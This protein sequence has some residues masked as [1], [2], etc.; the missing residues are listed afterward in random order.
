MNDKW[1]QKTWAKVVGAVFVLG[2]IGSMF[3]DNKTTTSENAT[4][5]E[6]TL[7]SLQMAEIKAKRYL[8]E[9]LKD[10]DSYEVISA[11][12]YFLKEYKGDTTKYKH[13]QSAIKY[14]AKNSFGGYV[15][16]QRAVT[17][18]EDFTPL[19]IFKFE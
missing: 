8:K 1:Y 5:I 16:E 18:S 14:R 13:I 12:T 17:M 6:K 15:V 11:E 3:G 9:S 2:V 19:E 4:E 10:P 7:P